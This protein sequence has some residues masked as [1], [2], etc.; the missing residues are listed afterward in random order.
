MLYRSRHLQMSRVSFSALLLAET[1]Q[2]CLYLSQHHVVIIFRSFIGWNDPSPPL[3]ISE[4]RHV[5]IL[6]SPI[7]WRDPTLFLFISVA[8]HVIIL[9]SLIGWRDPSPLLFFSVA[10][11]VII[12]A[13]LLAEGI[14]IRLC[15][16]QLHVT[17]SSS[18]LL[19]AKGIPMFSSANSSLPQTNVRDDSRSTY[20]FRRSVYV[21]E[22][23]FCGLWSSVD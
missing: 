17:W 4:A 2:R 10:R 13:L 12:P 21:S 16:S 3:F 1:I 19:L 7:G 11:H 20:E 8:R 9:S 15:F 14:Q 18:A 23:L 5:I 22:S 6:S